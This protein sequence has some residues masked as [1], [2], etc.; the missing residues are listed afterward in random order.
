MEPATDLNVSYALTVDETINE[1]YYIYQRAVLGMETKTLY[2]ITCKASASIPFY[3]EDEGYILHHYRTLSK[4]QD[5]EIIAIV[6]SVLMS[7]V[8]TSVVLYLVLVNIEI[9][10]KELN[11][12][13]ERVSS[14]LW[15][16]VPNFG[17][18]YNHDA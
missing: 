7:A 10:D 13:W 8:V 9:E 4:Y 2:N 17:T 11:F 5:W 14:V 3:F 1:G 15:K 18:E 6:A 16:Y 12:G